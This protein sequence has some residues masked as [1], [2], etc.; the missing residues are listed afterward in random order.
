M[1]SKSLPYICHFIIPS[2]I[3]SYNIADMSTLYSQ[4]M[5][6]YDLIQKMM[7]PYDIVVLMAMI[8]SYAER[9]HD[10]VLIMSNL[11]NLLVSTARSFD[12]VAR[13]YDLTWR[14][15]RPYTSLLVDDSQQGTMNL[16][17]QCRGRMAS[18]R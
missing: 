8:H 7:R 14:K 10:L 6:Y 18:C 15:M 17:G 3:I 4:D 16:R 11:C 12:H 13:S 1:Y 2:H 5:R 9:Y